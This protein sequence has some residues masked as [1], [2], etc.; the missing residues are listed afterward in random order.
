MG[1]QSWT[2]PNKYY[3]E[4]HEPMHYPGGPE[5]KPDE[6][7]PENHPV[8]GAARVSRSCQIRVHRNRFVEGRRFLCAAVASG[9]VDSVHHWGYGE[10]LRDAK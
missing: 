4:V 8:I 6:S 5:L 1:P 9:R 3:L 10:V 7:L 2:D